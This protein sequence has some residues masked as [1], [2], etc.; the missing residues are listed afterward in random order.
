MSAP[1]TQPSCPTL[2]EA[3]VS[4]SYRNL[5][6]LP[7]DHLA[8]RYRTYLAYG[9]SLWQRALPA[10]AL[11]AVDKALL[12]VLPDDAHVY[13]DHPLP[14]ATIV[15]FLENVDRSLFFGNPRVHYQHLAD[16]IRGEDVEL[17]SLRAWACWHLTRQS[18]PELPPDL[19]HA[20]APPAKQAI[21]SELQTAHR[22]PREAALL[23][24]LF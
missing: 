12:L 10:R 14:Y 11:L 16:R 18:R 21:L 1:T 19:S 17:R 5:R 8:A 4:M 24:L 6:A 22:R 9:Q 13:E 2:P 3:E 7:A 23:A 15:Y 20:V